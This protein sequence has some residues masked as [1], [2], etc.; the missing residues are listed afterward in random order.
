[1]TA[2]GIV[3]LAFLYYKLIAVIRRISNAVTDGAAGLWELS[4][5]SVL[6]T[7]ASARLY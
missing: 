1:M 6:T 4:D 2:F 5:N 7:C 3:K